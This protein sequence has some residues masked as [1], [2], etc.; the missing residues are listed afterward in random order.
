ME[1]ARSQR[2]NSEADSDNPCMLQID[3]DEVEIPEE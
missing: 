1:H 3:E 2:H